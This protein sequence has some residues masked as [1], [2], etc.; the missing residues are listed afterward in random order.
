MDEK[1]RLLLLNTVAVN[2]NVASL[3]KIGYSYPYIA[4]IYSQLINEELLIPNE[5]LIFIVSPKGK[6]EI[7][8][9]K[10]VVHK[11]KQWIIEPYI[12]FK[13]DKI[14]KYDIFIE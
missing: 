6:I 13:V 7:D 2:G 4:K 3:E 8:R 12:Q 9:L 10:K 5:D 1:I 11:K 14:D